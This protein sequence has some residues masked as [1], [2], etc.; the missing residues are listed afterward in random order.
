MTLLNPSMAEKHFYNVMEFCLTLAALEIY[1]PLTLCRKTFPFQDEQAG[2][3]GSAVGIPPA[4][5]FPIKIGSLGP[6]RI[7]RQRRSCANRRGAPNQTEPQFPVHHTK[8]DQQAVD[9]LDN[10]Q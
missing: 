4:T 9:Q 6:H 1:L 2:A 5:V 3:N 10:A 7:R 8:K